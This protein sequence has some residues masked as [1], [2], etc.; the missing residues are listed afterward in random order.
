MN[1]NVYK[2]IILIYTFN[3]LACSA[4][5]ANLDKRGLENFSQ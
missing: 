1:K 5:I 2:L 4:H 3:A